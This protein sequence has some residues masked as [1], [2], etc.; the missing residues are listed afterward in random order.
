M[1]IEGLRAPV[2]GG[3]LLFDGEAASSPAASALADR[4]PIASLGGKMLSYIA[5]ASRIKR[6]RSRSDFETNPKISHICAS[7][8]ATGFEALP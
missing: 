1:A 3:A 4:S 8:D 2:N 5:R 6:I 7:S